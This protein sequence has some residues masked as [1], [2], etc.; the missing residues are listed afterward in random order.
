MTEKN[1]EKQ[2]NLKK[3]LLSVNTLLRI[4]VNKEIDNKVRNRE[5]GQ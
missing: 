1:E 5:K 4:K 2:K 3:F